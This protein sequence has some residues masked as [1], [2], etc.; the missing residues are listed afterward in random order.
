MGWASQ[1]ERSLTLYIPDAP[2]NF[3][4]QRANSSWNREA[5]SDVELEVSLMNERICR[6]GGWI[7]ILIKADTSRL[8]GGYEVHFHP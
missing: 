5:S 2:L 6:A 7:L 4:G 1:P 3:N 8:H